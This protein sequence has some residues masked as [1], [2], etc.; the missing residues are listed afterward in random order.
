MTISAVSVCWLL[1]S[2]SSQAARVALRLP[3]LLPSLPTP[4]AFLRRRPKIPRRRER[5]CPM[6]GVRTG[7]PTTPAQRRRSASRET[8]LR[9]LRARPA[10]RLLPPL[11]QNLLSR[12]RRKQVNGWRM[13][14]HPPL[15]EALQVGFWDLT[16][17][18]S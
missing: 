6:R 8:G 18:A 3:S 15:H 13:L 7:A 5:T 14:Q 17:R 11:S 9:S 4:T 10:R 2:G 1:R 16:S 12:L